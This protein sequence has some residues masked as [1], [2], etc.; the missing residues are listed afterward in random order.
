MKKRK[1]GGTTTS[2]AAAAAI[3]ANKDD[4]AMS[5]GF[6]RD[7]KD[8]ADSSNQDTSMNRGK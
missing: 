7:K 2:T 3:Q 8:Q 5:S 6:Q 4:L 1:S